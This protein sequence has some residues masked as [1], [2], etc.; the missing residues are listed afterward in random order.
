LELAL[1]RHQAGAIALWILCVDETRVVPRR[2][3][4]LVFYRVRSR[5]ELEGQVVRLLDQ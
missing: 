1:D 3:R 5:E 4:D 2:A